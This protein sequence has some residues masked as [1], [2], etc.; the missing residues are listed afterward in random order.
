M[1]GSQ[2][3]HYMKKFRKCLND[4]G[5]L[6]FDV[7]NIE[8]SMADR[9]KAGWDGFNIYDVFLDKRINTARIRRKWLLG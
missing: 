6:V 4:N 7:C 2:R 9:K 5:I 3:M 1:I 8:Y